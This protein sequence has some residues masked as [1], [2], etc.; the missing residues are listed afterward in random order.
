M[1]KKILFLIALALPAFAETSEEPGFKALT[2]GTDLTGWKVVGGDG[3]Y[4][5]EGDQ[6]IGTGRN[7]KQNTFLRTQQTYKNFDLRFDM[8]FDTLDGNSGLMFRGLQ[9]PG[10]NGKVYGYQCEHD[11]GKDRA[12]T[13]GFYDES[14]RKWLVPFRNGDGKNDTE[15]QKAVQKAFT[16]HGKKIFK[17]DDWNQIRIVANGNHFQIWL[18]G[19]IRVDYIDVAPEFTSEGFIALQIHSG[20]AADV[21]WRNLRLKP[22]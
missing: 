19:E 16:E 6:V 10:E 11:N 18:N 2:N 7:V 15:A 9:K 8:K 22:L 20:K 3:Q 13:A 1:F 5:L 14:R 12:W 21:R 17:W 4:K